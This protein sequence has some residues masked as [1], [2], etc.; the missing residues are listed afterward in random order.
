MN[1]GGGRAAAF[2][3]RVRGNPLTRSYRVDKL[4]LAALEATLALYR[5]PERALREIPVLA[6]LGIPVGALRD[7]AR[8]VRERLGSLASLSRARTA[9]RCA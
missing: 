5:D 2:L 6:M 4:T 8:N 7:R 1:D 3:D 9:R